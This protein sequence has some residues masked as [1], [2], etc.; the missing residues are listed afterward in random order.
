MALG[1]RPATVQDG[2]AALA[3]IRRSILWLGHADHGGAADRIAA[4]LGNK[5]PVSWRAWARRADAVLLVADLAGG[6][7]GVGMVRADGEILL[8][9][10]DPDRSGRGIGTALLAAL[11]AE[12]RRR[13]AATAK[14]ES[15]RAALGFYRARGYAA[16][17]AHAPLRLGRALGG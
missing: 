4:W 12:A 10:V 5:T 8:L 9:Y 13:G 2:A 6:I 7:G 11:E 14:V 16:L 1:L 15:T 17:S 3:V